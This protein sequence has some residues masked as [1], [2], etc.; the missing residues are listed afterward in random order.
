MKRLFVLAVAAIV[1][2]SASTSEVQAQFGGRNGLGGRGNRLNRFGGGYL[3]GTGGSTLFDLYRTDQIPVPPYYSLHP[4]VYYNGIDYQR[5][6]TSPFAYPYTWWQQYGY[7]YNGGPPPFSGSGPTAACCG[8]MIDNSHATEKLEEV[9][10][11]AADTSLN[12]TA[13]AQLEI[14]NPF[15]IMPTETQLA[16]YAGER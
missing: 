16:E 13:K 5:Y 7:G 3:G 12:R 10:P 6:G 8:E 11:E 9:K 15:V 14:L 1:V 2:A 4:P